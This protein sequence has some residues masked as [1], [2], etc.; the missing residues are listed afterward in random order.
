M[1]RRFIYTITTG[2]SG[3]MFLSKLLELNLADAEVHHERANWLGLGV[4]S[5]DASHFTRY[6]SIGVTPEITAFWKRKLTLDAASP[7]SIYA[8]ASHL[9]SK[10]GLIEH[11]H[12][13]P[14]DSQIDL[15]IWRRPEEKIAWSYFNRMEFSNF[16]Y[17]WLFSLDPRY[18][19][20]IINGRTYL[21]AG[22][23]G[24]ALWYVREMFARAEYYRRLVSDLPNVTVY[25]LSLESV[26]QSEAPGDLERLLGIP[27][28]STNLPGKEN[29]AKVQNLSDAHR[30]MLF[31]LAQ[32][33]PVDTT[34]VGAEFYRS[35]RRLAS[36]PARAGSVRQAQRRVQTG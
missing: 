16:G 31:K 12:L 20:T 24:G 3:T 15:V 11:L 30:D 14:E 18:P 17:T 8:E 9:L 23:A 2:R 1:A 25:D 36:P 6:N 10:A 19:N 26:V 28:A 32:N 33:N 7:K 29:E 5:P 4:H 21:Q 34:A 35:G 27:A 22:A 13:L